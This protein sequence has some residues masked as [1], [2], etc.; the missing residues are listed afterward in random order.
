MD[1]ATEAVIEQATQAPHE[2]QIVDA[3]VEHF[4]R[5]RAVV[6]TWLLSLDELLLKMAVQA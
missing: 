3:L 2:D 4:G 1:Q 5:P 6:V